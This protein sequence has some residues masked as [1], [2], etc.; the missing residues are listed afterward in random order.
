[1]VTNLKDNIEVRKK[2]YSPQNITLKT[3]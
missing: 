3:T 2:S 1:M